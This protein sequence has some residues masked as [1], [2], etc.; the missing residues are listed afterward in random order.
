MTGAPPTSPFRSR[1]AIIFA[2]GSS[3]PQAVLVGGAGRDGLNASGGVV[4]L[5][6]IDVVAVPISSQVPYIVGGSMLGAVVLALFGYTAW[7]NGRVTPTDD[8]LD[9]IYSLGSGAGGSIAIERV[10]LLKEAVRGGGAAG[11]G[12][13]GGGSP[14][15]GGGGTA[16]TP[17]TTAAPPTA[18]RPRGRSR[19]SI[20]RTA[21]MGSI[22][23]DRNFDK[24]AELI[25]DFTESHVA[26]SV[27]RF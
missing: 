1:A 6:E 16:A 20:K 25:T 3:N 14:P 8:A 17:A 4:V 15:R 22:S 7:R 23:A 27:L 21:S 26:D 13:G 2:D 5:S 12:D 24:D 11:G 19:S 10:G 9:S 18:S